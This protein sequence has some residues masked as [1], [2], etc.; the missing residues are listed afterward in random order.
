[1]EPQ[2]GR[3]RELWSH[4]TV[5]IFGAGRLGSLCFMVF[6]ASRIAAESL[7]ILPRKQISRAM[8]RLADLPAPAGVLNRVMKLYM[9]AYNVDLAECI[10]PP[11]GFRTFDEFFT[12]QLLP[13]SRPLDS[14]R[15]AVLSPA[16]GRIEDMGP[17]SAS[18]TFLVKGQTY[19]AATLLGGADEAERFAGGLFFIVYLSPRDYHRVHAPV[20]GAVKRVRY[21]PGTLFPVNRIGLDHVPMLFA[22]N[23][24]VAV[25]QESEHHGL[26]A[27]VMVGAIGVGRIG[28]SFC[29]LTTNSGTPPARERV[30]PDSNTALS[31]GAEL[32]MFHL[33][34]TAIVFVEKAKGMRLEPT[35]G[36]HCK[37]GTAVAVA[38]PSAP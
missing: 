37:M 12:R 19:D 21:V 4:A 25:F 15:D 36:S 34:S 20:T 2:G 24:R 32:G 27:T 6:S 11:Q 18:R 29:D 8:G 31:R 30:F 10:V 1:M 14:R 17:V 3:P 38:G 26:V 35:L 7:K 13:G 23:E 16:D 33:G 22:R 5:A 9:S 28:L